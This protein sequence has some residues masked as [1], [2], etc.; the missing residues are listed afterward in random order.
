MTA[1][2]IRSAICMVMLFG[3][4]WLILRKEKLFI[5]NRYYLIL[6]VLFSLTVPFVSIPVDIGSQN[7]VS[8]IAAALNHKPELN[9]LEYRAGPVNPE[10]PISVFADGLYSSQPSSTRYAPVES[11]NILLIIYLTEKI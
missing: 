9:S 3:L 11:K 5:F 4:Y 7:A 2:I 6:S 10:E 1:F 8:E